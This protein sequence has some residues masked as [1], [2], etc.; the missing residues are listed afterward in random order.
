MLIK[1]YAMLYVTQSEAIG[2]TQ[3]LILF[4][5]AYFSEYIIILQRNNVNIIFIFK[6]AL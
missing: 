1:D 3:C 6:N 5:Q 2:I 4:I